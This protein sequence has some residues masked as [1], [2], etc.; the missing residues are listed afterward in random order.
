MKYI[1]NILHNIT[2]HRKILRKERPQVK[3]H[4]EYGRIRTD[5]S[6]RE[7]AHH[8]SE[9]YPFQFYDEDIWQFDFHCVD[10]HWHPEVELMFIETGK[11]DFLIG[12][13]R[14]TLSSGTGVFINAQVVHRF[15]S[16]ESTR[17]PNIVFSPALLSQEESLIYQKYIRPVLDSPVK[18]QIFTFDN[19]DQKEILDTLLS[20]F[21]IQR[22]EHICEIRTVETLM[23][24][25]RMI[26]ESRGNIENAPMQQPSARTQAQLQI[27]LQYIHKNYP[28]QISL[29]DIANTV[30]LSK[31]SVLNI[32]NKNIHTSPVNYLV[33]YRLKCAAKL[34]AITEDSVLSIA[35]ET[36]FENVGYFCRKFK[37]TFQLTP[38]E[39][40]KRKKDSAQVLSGRQ[41]KDNKR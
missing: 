25:W 6:L 39:Y 24:L 22:S 20:V 17:I 36:G 37:D 11:A 19:P 13:D 1:A 7:I 40:R 34:L 15:E 9:E 27:M 14:H 10:W 33:N 21:A 30:T 2:K 41:S 5:G 3:P 18:Y 23:R 28:Y 29:D 8:G 38:G 31:S 35:H 16:T 32:F 12:S 4:T 26:Y